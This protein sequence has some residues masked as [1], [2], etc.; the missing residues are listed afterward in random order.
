MKKVIYTLIALVFLSC[1]GSARNNAKEYL[2]ILTPETISFL[3]SEKP[4]EV[5]PG[6]YLYR[7]KLTRSIVENFYT[8]VTADR[9]ITGAILAAA[10]TN[11]ISLPLAF[12]LAWVESSYQVTALN[13][14]SNSVDRGLFQLNSR[15]FP[16]LKE[17][18]FYDPRINAEY[19]L[20]H[21]RYCLEKGKNEVVALAMYNAGITRVHRGTPYSTLN[22]VA[23]ILDNKRQLV[24]S[25][26]QMLTENGEIAKVLETVFRTEDS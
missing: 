5:D 6:L 4:E 7:N 18:H 17:E 21:F 19:G 3:L 2:D 13:R 20:A 1:S 26:E 11:D 10:D 8:Q 14:N 9:E 25:F 16:N 15:T 12:S 22:Y 24:E 23:R